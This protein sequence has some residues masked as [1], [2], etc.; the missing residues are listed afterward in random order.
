MTAVELQTMLESAINRWDAEFE[1]KERSLEKH[2]AD[3]G[4]ID[5]RVKEEEAEIE[6]SLNETNEK[7]NT[8]L[9]LLEKDQVVA[10]IGEHLDKG[11]YP[12]IVGLSKTIYDSAMRTLRLT[13]DFDAFRKLKGRPIPLDSLKRKVRAHFTLAELYVAL[14][15]RIDPSIEDK[16]ARA[17]Y[18]KVITEGEQL[19]KELEK[20]GNSHIDRLRLAH[21]IAASYKR[22]FDL[23]LEAEKSEEYGFVKDGK[24]RHELI[25]KA[26][27]WY[28]KMFDI[29]NRVETFTSEDAKKLFPTSYEFNRYLADIKELEA[30]CVFQVKAKRRP[31]FKCKNP[32]NCFHEDNRFCYYLHGT[33]DH[34]K[35]LERAERIELSS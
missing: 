7:F 6:R 35:N 24:E 5:K 31:F 3:T 21:D 11:D 10:P 9:N 20:Q 23:Y 14:G 16:S 19:Y 12:K 15:V 13:R 27:K 1:E 33:E 17:E 28:H 32:F 4:D 29:A 8:L 30:G 25:T 2:F 26:R 18:E 22:L 34:R